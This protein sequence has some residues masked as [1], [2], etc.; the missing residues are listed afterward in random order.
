MNEILQQIANACVPIVCLL[1]TAGGAYLVA[2][3]RKETTQL[4][5]GIDNDTANKYI[6]MACDA[7]TQAVTYTAQTFVDAL[8]A[9]DA[10]TKEKQLEAF[11][12]AK[13]KV[14]QILGDSAVAA[15]EEIYGD[16]DAWMNTRIEQVCREIKVPTTMLLTAEC[17]A[18]ENEM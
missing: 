1:I 17:S 10:F 3:I 13:K 11:C 15:L 18:V 5:K 14:V 9:E 6:D 16:F 4:Q 12:I 7:V 2:L 8:K